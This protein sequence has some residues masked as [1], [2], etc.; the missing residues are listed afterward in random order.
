MTT[1]PSFGGRWHAPVTLNVRAHDREVRRMRASAGGVKS[2]ARGAGLP[3]CTRI[4]PTACRA[5]VAVQ[6]FTPIASFSQRRFQSTS[7]PPRRCTASHRAGSA[8]LRALAP[9]SV[10]AP[11]GARD[12]VHT[13]I[14]AQSASAHRFAMQ[15][16][17]PNPVVNRTR[18]Y[19]ASSTE[20]WWR[21]AGYLARW[22]RRSTPST[23]KVF[24]SPSALWPSI[25]K[26]EGARSKKTAKKRSVV[27]TR[28]KLA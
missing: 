24:T 4:G 5:T 25:R 1:R 8:R 12:S 11:G 14:A 3:W 13:C 16:V 2:P 17:R 6:W 20:R 22:D 27:P 18:R 9:V 10:R 23:M 28:N 21:R 26:A 19:A 15:R 7:L